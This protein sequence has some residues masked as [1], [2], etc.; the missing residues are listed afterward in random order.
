MRH[1]DERIA[2]I[3]AEL[4]RSDVPGDRR[5]SLL[6][7]YNRLVDQKNLIGRDNGFLYRDV[8]RLQ[9]ELQAKLR[10]FGR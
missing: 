2:A 3:R 9:L 5:G 8:D 6:N 4:G 7:E 1:N 10:E